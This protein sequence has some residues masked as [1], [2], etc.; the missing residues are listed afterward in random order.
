ML[1][2]DCA[3]EIRI[4][5][6]N[7]FLSKLGIALKSFNSPMSTHSFERKTNEK[8]MIIHRSLHDFEISKNFKTQNALILFIAYLINLKMICEECKIDS[9]N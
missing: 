4:T 8:G 5:D 1:S 9:Q 6:A 7:K 3:G 2:F